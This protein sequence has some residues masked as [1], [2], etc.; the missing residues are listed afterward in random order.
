M[1]ISQKAATWKTK[2]ITGQIFVLWLSENLRNNT[3]WEVYRTILVTTYY[4]NPQENV[5]YFESGWDLLR[6]RTARENK[7]FFLLLDQC[8]A[9][10]NK[11][12]TLKQ[13]HLTTWLSTA[14]TVHTESTS[15]SFFL[16]KIHRNVL[17]ADTRTW[18]IPETDGCYDMEI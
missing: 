5:R 8:S 1:N 2:D 10:N 13:H 18:N 14:W 3:D 16:H 12:L 17:T 15:C 11:G 7:N 9:H 4:L 6:G